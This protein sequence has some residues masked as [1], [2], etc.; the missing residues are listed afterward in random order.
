MA[1]AAEQE[2]LRVDPRCLKPTPCWECVPALR[3]RLERG[4]TALAI[5]DGSR[6]RLTRHSLLVREPLLVADRPPLEAVEAMAWGL[7]ED[8]LN[9][10]YRHHFAV[11]LRHAGRLEDAEAELRKVLEIDEN[12]P[13]AL[14]TLGAVCAQQGRFEEALTCDREGACDDALGESDRRAV[15]GAPGSRRSQE[16]GRRV[17]REARD[18]QGIRSADWAGSF[19]R[20]LWRIRSGGGMGGASDRRAVSATRRDPG[21]APA[22]HSQLAC[23]GETDESAGVTRGACEKPSCPRTAGHEP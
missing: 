14:G 8:P 21:A 12:F 23:P 17:A 19:S 2:A 1:R 3:L 10:L 11:G 5:G 4:G 16:P 13:L 6:T 7:Q 15:R 9:L 18:W 22:I 20:T